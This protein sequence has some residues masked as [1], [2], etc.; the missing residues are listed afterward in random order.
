M[1]A[2]RLISLLLVM[3]LLLGVFPFSAFAEDAIP[4]EP[5]GYA[6][7]S[8]Q[9]EEPEEILNEFPGEEE[10]LPADEEDD[11][12]TGSGEDDPFLYQE[13]ILSRVIQAEI[14]KSVEASGSDISVLA[15]N[16]ERDDEKGCYT[17]T[18][19]YHAPSEALIRVEL[20]EDDD[21]DSVLVLASGETVV[22]GDAE[23]PFENLYAE[24]EVFPPEGSELPDYFRVLY[25]LELLDENGN[26][27]GEYTEDYNYSWTEDLCAPVFAMQSDSAPSSA[28]APDGIDVIP[29]GDHYQPLGPRYSQNHGESSSYVTENYLIY[30][31]TSYVV[32]IE[33][34]DAILGEG[35]T[36]ENGSYTMTAPTGLQVM[37]QEELENISAIVF[38]DADPYSHRVFVPA[39]L[40]VNTDTGKMTF[41]LAEQQDQSDLEYLNRI[42]SRISI[43]MEISDYT[44]GE[45]SSFGRISDDYVEGYVSSPDLGG[46]ISTD[47]GWIYFEVEAELDLSCDFDLRIK[48]ATPN[49]PSSISGEPDTSRL[50]KVTLGKKNY[51]L[52]IASIDVDFNLFVAANNP[53][54]LAGTLNQ[55]AVGSMRFGTDGGFSGRTP[56]SVT[57]SS[58]VP[59][60]NSETYSYV[61]VSA[62]FMQYVG[63]V[64]AGAEIISGD[65]MLSKMNR[66]KYL[67]ATDKDGHTVTNGKIHYCAFGGDG[68][69][70]EIRHRGTRYVRF[71]MG[72]SFSIFG[73]DIDLG[74]PKEFSSKDGE[75]SCFCSKT[76]NEYINTSAECSHY[77]Y[78]VDAE[79]FNL[80][81]QHEEGVNIAA[82]QSALNSF[83]QV[84][85]EKAVSVTGSTG[86]AKLYLPNG[87]YTL[88]ARNSIAGGRHGGVDGTATVEISSRATSVTIYDS[89]I[90]TIDYVRGGVVYSGQNDV[91][92][93]GILMPGEDGGSELPVFYTPGHDTHIRINRSDTGNP[94]S[95]RDILLDGKS[96]LSDSSLWESSST[97]DG[98]LKIT[99]FEKASGNIVILLNPH[100]INCIKNARTRETYSSLQAAVNGADSGDTLI[101]MGDIDENLFGGAVT[102]DKDLYLCATENSSYTVTNSSDTGITVNSGVTLK[103]GYA[104]EKYRNLV[105]APLVI[106]GSSDRNAKTTIDNSGNLY[107]KN[108]DMEGGLNSGPSGIISSG[109]LDIID[110]DIKNFFTAVELNNATFSLNSAKIRGCYGS[111]IVCSASQGKL[112][113]VTISDCGTGQTVERGGGLYINS[114]SSVDLSDV[115][116]KNCRA[117]CGGGIFVERLSALNV[118]SVSISG[119]SAL[120]YGGGLYT[121]ESI[122]LDNANFADNKAQEG[123]G[124]YAKSVNTSEYGRDPQRE[125]TLN[126]TLFRKNQ[127]SK[128]SAVYSDGKVILGSQSGG[129]IFVTQSGLYQT[130][131]LAGSLSFLKKNADFAKSLIIP[132]TLDE[133]QYTEGNTVVYS[134][135]ATVVSSDAK[136]LILM[137]E[138]GDCTVAY[139][140]AVYSPELRL[141]FKNDFSI[142]YFKDGNILSSYHP[143]TRLPG[144]DM[145]RSDLPLTFTSRTVKEIT[146]YAAEGADTPHPE[147]YLN[148]ADVT[149]N[150]SYCSVAEDKTSKK[151]VVTIKENAVG[152]ITVV[153]GSDDVSV[154]NLDKKVGYSTLRAAVEDAESSDTL[155]IIKDCNEART[156]KSGIDMIV[157]SKDLNIVALNSPKTVNLDI[158]LKINSGAKVNF[159]ILPSGYAD[160]NP[161]AITLKSSCIYTMF[162]L[163][164]LLEIGGDSTA[165]NA[166]LLNVNGNKGDSGVRGIY[167][168]DGAYFSMTGGSVSNCGDGNQIG[169]GIYVENGTVNL[170]GVDI[171]NNTATK[172]AGI[173]SRGDTNSVTMMDCTVSGNTA[174]YCAGAIYIEG[175]D[176][177]ISGGSFRLNTSKTGNCV[178]V[179]AASSFKMSGSPI[180]WSSQDVYLDGDTVITKAGEFGE[181]VVIPVEL[182]NHN[183]GRD[184]LV[185][186]AESSVAETDLSHLRWVD[187]EDRYQNLVFNGSQ[188]VIEISTCNII[189]STKESGYYTLAEAVSEASAG[190][191]LV[192]IA[193]TVEE[194]GDITLDKQICIDT[195]GAHSCTLNGSLIITYPDVTFCSY[196]EETLTLKAGSDFTNGLRGILNVDFS[197]DGWFTVPR[198]LHI[199]GDGK[200]VTGIRVTSGRLLVAGGEIKNNRAADGAGIYLDGTSS[201]LISGYAGFSGNTGNAV[202]VSQNAELEITGSPVFARDESDSSGD[203]T[204]DLSSGAALVKNSA[205]KITDGTVIPVKL[206]TDPE[207]GRDVLISKGCDVADGMQ[208]SFDWVNAPAGCALNFNLTGGPASTPCVEVGENLARVLNADTKTYYPSLLAAVSDEG[209][210]PGHTLVIL[211]DITESAALT[212]DKSLYICSSGNNVW[213]EEAG[214]VI[215]AGAEVVFGSP[216]DEYKDNYI[217]TITLNTDERLDTPMITNHGNLTIDAFVLDGAGK[218]KAGGIVT[219]GTLILH[220]AAVI[221]NCTSEVSSSAGGVTVNGGRCEIYGGEFS[222]NKAMS[223]NGNAVYASSGEL[224]ISGSPMF[225]DIGAD[226]Q[227][228]S[229]VQYVCLADNVTIQKNGELDATVPLLLKGEEPG[230]DIYVS[231]DTDTVSPDDLSRFIWFKDHAEGKLVFTDQ[232]AATGKPV[233]EIGEGISPVYNADRGFYFDNLGI[234]VLTAGSGDTLVFIGDA[235][236][237]P[238][239]ININKNLYICSENNHTDT[240]PSAAYLNIGQGVSVRFG[241]TGREE[242]SIYNTGILT[243][244][245]D[246]DTTYTPAEYGIITA[247]NANISLLNA[248]IDG[249]NSVR[250]MYLVSGMAAVQNSVIMNCRAED[251][252]GAYVDDGAV[253]TLTTGSWIRNNTAS[254]SGGGIYAKGSVYIL[255]AYVYQ[256]TASDSGGGIYADVQGDGDVNLGS[257]AFV[258]GNIAP[259]GG[260][261]YN[262]R[263]I[264]V[265]GS[266][267]INGNFTSGDDDNKKNNNVEN[268]RDNEALIYILGPLA[269]GKTRIDVT[270]VPEEDD[271]DWKYITSGYEDFH[272]NSSSVTNAENF[273]V[274]DDGD[275]HVDIWDRS[276]KYEAV[277]VKG[278]V[279]PIPVPIPVPVPEPPVPVPPVPTP[280]PEEDDKFHK[281]KYKRGESTFPV[282]DLPGVEMFG[283][284][285]PIAMLAG[286]PVQ[287][288]ISP[289]EGHLVPKLEKMTMKIGVGKLSY[290]MEIDPIIEGNS[291]WLGLTIPSIIGDV[292]VTLNDEVT[293]TFDSNGG[294]YVEPQLLYKNDKA[295]EP[296]APKKE[297]RYFDGWYLDNGS[298]RNRYDF[299]SPVTENITLYAKWRYIPGTGLNTGQSG[300]VLWLSAISL[301]ALGAVLLLSRRRKRKGAD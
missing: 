59:E 283:S 167:V 136:N 216:A 106:I 279:P 46:R 110:S 209:T 138:H 208:N 95:V 108:T 132:L 143:D 99:I 115:S 118:S 215:S 229:P 31:D 116:I 297:N 100:K 248:V 276:G 13:D 194:A 67:P 75:Q 103:I 190:D 293:V 20:L 182:P 93:E 259:H 226:I 92:L 58:V 173:Y 252:A 23:N 169:Q 57:Y 201:C 211:E 152:N 300:P 27:S 183:S 192:F 30:A 263:R 224:A 18:V 73:K 84:V 135:E 221:R 119:C 232:D 124:V 246:P 34:S 301:T 292:T 86:H 94:V 153:L 117:N 202:Y 154:V 245:A 238:E 147:V 80:L 4:E 193:D 98:G 162:H 72:I 133:D 44:S 240:L 219:D 7:I 256:N 145:D 290:D 22:P 39:D 126:N 163:G 261:I 10:P 177:S 175:G 6:Q 253:L 228:G 206:E 16:L 129:E 168:R 150:S 251:G 217:G 17:A 76:F 291:D 286:L 127:A 70:T 284:L 269:K 207:A 71:D 166:V 91:R 298:F 109:Y 43:D 236:E 203:Q 288:I 227:N 28:P 79:F 62:G 158:P 196:S 114:S 270:H 54:K 134:G 262:A 277:L 233:I 165:V 254:R 25:S 125:L 2:R 171:F 157:I 273:F 266:V 195:D 111:G 260:G 265:Q 198:E 68:G 184:V 41:R 63:P 191:R 78:L 52:G 181:N 247:V 272:S 9:Q 49:C 77:G 38:L 85:R 295:S 61:G 5:A 89:T 113:G 107:I 101:F 1:R 29:E 218:A 137:P 8:G 120:T 296:Q 47:Y 11:E 161:C 21:P 144:I 250:G 69:C 140:P 275:Y 123:G 148:N 24:V 280:D 244:K 282:D 170:N 105:L 268:N 189:N 88:E 65:M 53:I 225:G 212:I 222:G 287:I 197:D 156:V 174:K 204:V 12:D 32:S 185:S 200:D 223:G 230:R 257:G 149:N 40:Q 112:T 241:E 151:A 131:Y 102:V 281:I 235:A 234:A 160:L 155:A 60:R 294:T 33:E 82:S 51:G 187:R 36:S 74:E 142:S 15:V 83:P 96:I 64:R 42:Y 19:A 90:R 37:T 267:Q 121:E 81:R 50:H 14:D 220:S 26:P 97:F 255:N 178:D 3:T 242:Y 214:T 210:L 249:S 271:N 179:K 274:S 237:A 87:N 278:Y 231:T 164:T 213:T 139:S 141:S 128:G 104:G 299:N 146:L 122:R 172:G 176:F 56:G 66:D 35:F 55:S 130:V 239:P 159:G 258:C 205:E 199:D 48:K 285:M 186:S 45:M 264:S 180:F 243:L 188:S 289:Q